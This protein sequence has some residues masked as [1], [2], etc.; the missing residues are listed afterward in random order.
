[1]FQRSG[2]TVVML[3]HTRPAFLPGGLDLVDDLAIERPD[4]GPARRAAPEPR[5]EQI[6]VDRQV[7]RWQVEDRR[8]RDR[9]IVPPAGPERLGD[10][11]GGADGRMLARGRRTFTSTRV[12]GNEAR[13]VEL[14]VAAGAADAFPAAVA[15]PPVVPGPGQPLVSR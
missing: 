2:Q 5:T 15:C 3:A 14:V 1:M 7:G 12:A 4:F 9:V 6:R 10:L 13:V 8:D 11:G